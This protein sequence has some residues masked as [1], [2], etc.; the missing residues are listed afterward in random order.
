MNRM[1]DLISRQEVSGCGY[2][3]SESN[4]CSLYRPSAEQ[5]GRWIPVTDGLPEQEGQYLVSCGTDYGIEVARMY[6]D[7]DGERYFGCDWNDPDDIE[8]WMPLPEPYKRG[9]WKNEKNDRPR[10]I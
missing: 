7:E 3:D 9:E 1:D 2:W 8:A 10:N 6:I 5:Y 4:F